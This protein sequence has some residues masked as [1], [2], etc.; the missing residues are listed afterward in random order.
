MSKKPV[1]LWE[2]D[3]DMLIGAIEL[4]TRQVMADRKADLDILFI[5]IDHLKNLRS[6]LKEVKTHEEN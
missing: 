3:L 5:K 4:L 6:R 1:R 2:E